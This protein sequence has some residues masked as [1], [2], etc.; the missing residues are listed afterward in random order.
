MFRP[1]AILSFKYDD[2]LLSINEINKANTP[3]INNDPTNISK[4]YSIPNTNDSPK[5]AELEL[6]DITILY[7]TIATA[8]LNILSP[9]II[10]YK[11]TSASISLKIASTDTG[12]VALIKLP[13]ANASYQVNF[14]LRCISP[15][16]QNINELEKNAIKVPKNEY[17][18]TVP[19]FLKKYFLFILYPDSNII[20]GSR[21]ITKIPLK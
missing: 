1:P 7:N 17:I 8:S 18:S 11:S 16:A 12:S 14:L 6:D 3:P 10:A 4:N 19:A 5:D 13:K 15:V 21:I 20:G 9:N 2:Y